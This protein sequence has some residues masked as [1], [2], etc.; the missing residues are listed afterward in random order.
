MTIH[1]APR[2]RWTAVAVLSAMAVLAAV[3]AFAAKALDRPNFV[4]DVAPILHQNCVS[5]HRP[6]EIAPMALRTYDEVRPWAKSIG[7]AVRDRDMPPWDADPGFGPFANDISLSGDEIEMIS[8]WV[9]AGA[10]RGEGDE[11]VVPEPKKSGEWTLGE[12]DW[13]YEF[14]PYE[15]AAD[16]PDHFNIIPIE[17]GWEEDRW[18][19]SIEVLP[20]DGKVV[21]HFILWQADESG[22]GP[23]S[24]LSGWAAGALWIQRGRSPGSMVRP[25]AMMAAC[26]TV[27]LSSRTLPGYS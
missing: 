24:W 2:A 7:K 18:I 6:G 5:C 13:I 15:V 17:T 11:P 14:D 10:P 21:H 4:D 22:N 9:A 16:G 27:F 26:S 20:G 8:R 12:P 1:C 19:E 3:P 23:E 25:C